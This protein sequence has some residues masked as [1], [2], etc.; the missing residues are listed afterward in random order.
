M[1]HKA[2]QKDDSVRPN[3]I[4]AVG[5]L[6]LNLLNSI[7]AHQVVQIVEDR[8]LT[9]MGLRTLDIPNPNYRRVYRGGVRERDAAYHQGTVWPWLKGPFVEA[10]LR[11]RGNNAANRQT[12]MSRFVQPLLDHLQTAGLGHV[13]EVADGE[14]PHLP[15]GC[16]F[17][18]LSMGELLRMQK[19]GRIH[20]MSQSG[21]P[22]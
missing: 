16:P 12:A 7:K 5:G 21:F 11:V 8:L 18:A 1:D 9:P 2:G 20:R 13:S 15:A 22:N 17:Q 4:F 14:W 10:W 3:Q 6:P 19:I